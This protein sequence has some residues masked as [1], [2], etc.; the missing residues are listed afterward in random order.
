MMLFLRQV[1]SRSIIKVIPQNRLSVPFYGEMVRCTF[2]QSPPIERV[3]QT[4]GE[5]FLRILI[6]VTQGHPRS[7]SRKNTSKFCTFLLRDGAL[8]VLAT[9]TNRKSGSNYRWV[10][11]GGLN[12]T[13][14]AGP[15]AWPSDVVHPQCTCGSLITRMTC[16]LSV[17]HPDAEQ[18]MKVSNFDSCAQYARKTSSQVVQCRNAA[19][20]FNLRPGGGGSFCPTPPVVFRG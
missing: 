14:P 15:A 9:T 20:F 6:R 16:C 11:C 12:G 13:P 19:P 4:T 5:S 17:C 10:F 8:H 3:G 7:I 1:H 2:S 18:P